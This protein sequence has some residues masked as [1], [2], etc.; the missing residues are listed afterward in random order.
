MYSLCNDIVSNSDYIVLNGTNNELES[1]WTEMGVTSGDEKF[2]LL[3]PIQKTVPLS[4]NL[5]TI[6]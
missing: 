4:Q 1:T 6:T 5:V 2:H 3:H